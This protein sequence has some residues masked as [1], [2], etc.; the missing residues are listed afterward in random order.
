MLPS[1]FSR[2]EFWNHL[3]QIRS[4]SW[5]GGD[6]LSH[7]E[8]WCRVFCAPPGDSQHEPYSHTYCV[9]RQLIGVTL[10]QSRARSTVPVSHWLPGTSEMVPECYFEQPAPEFR[11]CHT[12]QVIVWLHGLL[13]QLFLA[14]SRCA[15]VLMV[16]VPACEFIE[17]SGLDS[18]YLHEK[19][20]AKYDCFVLVPSGDSFLEL[21]QWLIQPVD[22]S[23]CRV[24]SF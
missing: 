4:H 20:F 18:S 16:I 5:L 11:H 17:S 6:S 8:Y 23:G 2:N 22:L 10:S 12:G 15:R 7:W 14:K 13:S 1:Q 24:L 3:C 21:F 19:S 9:S